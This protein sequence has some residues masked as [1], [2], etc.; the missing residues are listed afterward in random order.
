MTAYPSQLSVVPSRPLTERVVT[1]IGKALRAVDILRAL[2][3]DTRARR[4]EA[5][6][7]DGIADMNEHMLKDIGAHERLISHAAMRGDADHRQRISA[8]LLLPVL[9]VALMATAAPDAA[10]AATDSP[11]TSKACDQAQVVGVFTGE[12]VNGA[13]VYRLPPVVVVASRKVE[14]AKLG[15]E[16]QSTRARQARAKAATRHPA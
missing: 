2:W 15:H 11:P 14:R 1:G 10:G 7:V 8:Q 5:R 9:V 13:P 4:R 6:A 12:Y 16:E 3:R